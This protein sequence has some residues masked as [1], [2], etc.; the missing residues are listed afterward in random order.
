MIK[1]KDIS[2]LKDYGFK[3]GISP[4]GIYRNGNGQITYDAYGKRTWEYD[5]QDNRT[6]INIYEDD[7]IVRIGTPYG[8]IPAKELTCQIDVLFRLIVDGHCELFMG[9]ENE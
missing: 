2:I 9:Y 1:V 6:Y 5:C 4:S 7:K 8:D 3:L